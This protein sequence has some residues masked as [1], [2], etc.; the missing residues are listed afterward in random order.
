MGLYLVETEEKRLRRPRP[1]GAGLMVQG[2]TLDSICL[3]CRA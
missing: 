2:D 3:G 1:L